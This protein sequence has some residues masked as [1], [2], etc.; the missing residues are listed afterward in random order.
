MCARQEKTLFE[1]FWCCKINVNGQL[2]LRFWP[3]RLCIKRVFGGASRR[4]WCI[5]RVHQ[6]GC[7]K[8]IWPIMGVHQLCFLHQECASR[9]L[10]LGRVHQEGAST[11]VGALR[12]RIKRNVRRQESFLILCDALRACTAKRGTLLKIKNPSILKCM[13][14]IGPKAAVEE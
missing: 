2:T 3:S 14:E 9:G 6:E 13:T 12:G 7:I 10:F 1:P 8:R 11:F 4:F 5:K